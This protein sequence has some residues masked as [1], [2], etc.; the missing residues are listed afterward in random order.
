[1]DIRQDGDSFWWRCPICPAGAGAYGLRRDR[2]GVADY[3]GRHLA[4]VHGAACGDAL[5]PEAAAAASREAATIVSEHQQ[6][7]A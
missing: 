6:R 5:H 7:K 2:Q 1:M 4:R 3:A